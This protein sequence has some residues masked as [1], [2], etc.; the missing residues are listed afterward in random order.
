MWDEDEECDK[1]QYV[2]SCCLMKFIKVEDYQYTEI[3][4]LLWKQCEISV[5]TK[6]K[7]LTHI[8]SVNFQRLRL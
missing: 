6:H 8:S 1:C 3:G 7:Q 5:T 4:V 2:P